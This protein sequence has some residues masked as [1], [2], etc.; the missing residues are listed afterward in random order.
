MTDH[1][2]T[3][4]S[5][6]C[7]GISMAS[8]RIPITTLLVF[9]FL[10]C[11]ELYYLSV[12]GRALG[13]DGRSPLSLSPRLVCGMAAKA[14]SA[15]DGEVSQEDR[16]PIFVLS[17]VDELGL[18]LEAFRVYG[19]LARRVGSN[20]VAWP[21]YAKIGED[22]FRGSLP[23]AKPDSL[24]R[25]AMRAVREL[26]QLGLIKVEQRKAGKR[27]RTNHYYVKMLRDWPPETRAKVKAR[28]AS[29]E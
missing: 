15:K 27:N 18:S 16:I 9:P 3:S 14:K 20:D 6:V 17:D 19:H 29:M 21:S 5:D 22:C 28:R 12:V 10:F 7:D 8:A 11:F 1:P 23:R 13:G 4:D 2:C 25:K 24:R 26:E